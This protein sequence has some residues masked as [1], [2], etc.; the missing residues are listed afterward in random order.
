M[1]A[2]YL[3]QADTG[4]WYVHW[5]ENRIGKR[6]STKT[7]NQAE[8]AAFLS[9]WLQN[10][11]KSGVPSK[12]MT[13]ADVWTVYK[14]K[15]F[16]DGN[17][18]ADFAWKNLDGAFGK[19]RAAAVTQALI[20]DYVDQRVAGKIGRK[21]QPQTVAK[22]LSYLVAALNFCSDPRRALIAKSGPFDLPAAGD[23]RDRWLRT[24]EIQ[25]LLSAAASM[26]KGDRLSR[27]ERFLWL[28]LET[29]GRAQALLE[30]TWDRVDFET[31]M[32]SLNVPGRRK[33]K[34]RRADVPMSAALR[35]VLLRAHAERENDYVLDRAT[36][37]W[38]TIQSIAVAAGLAPRGERVS[39][40]GISPHVLRHTA[41]THMARRGVSIFHIAKVL[42][43]SVTTTERVYAK[44][45]P[46]D[47]QKA[48]D[49]IS[50]GELETIR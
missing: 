45:V 24:H 21:V 6:V 47:L 16:P 30:L 1:N 27:G 9:R 43:N 36:P 20:D 3:K 50:N 26:R 34:K 40:T 39:A 8:A 23:P 49:L 19:L 5:T 32:I 37:I 22:E 18:G 42:G 13:V 46:G 12:D 14:A 38:Q 4:V 11:E 44:Y 41:A 33:T 10:T 28:A 2:P 15:R 29:A 25:R 7:K 31:G 48:V 17:A 35:P